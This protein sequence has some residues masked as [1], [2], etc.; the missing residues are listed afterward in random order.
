V[1]SSKLRTVATV[2]C[3]VLC[4]LAITSSLLLFYVSRVLFHP[5]AFADRV[6]ASLAEPGVSALVATRITDSLIQQRRN[7]VAFRPII[8]GTTESLISSAP[9]RAVVQRAAKAA[10]RTMISQ[11]GKDISLSVGDASVILQSALSSTPKL[12]EKIPARVTTLLGSSNEAPGGR[13][14]VKLVRFAHNMRIGAVALLVVG[15][16]LGGTAF[17]LVMDR[18][19]FLLRMGIALALIA[20]ILRLSVR[21]GGTTLA[22]FAKDEMVGGA[23]AGLWHA[24]LSGFMTWALILG[25]IGLVLAAGVTSL[26]SRVELLEIGKV[27]RNWFVETHKKASIRLLR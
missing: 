2:L 7:L 4:L 20:L 15:I 22:L 26:F 21:F 17:I 12:A 5:Q 8:L 3:S 11:R 9:F 19:R 24:F 14:I 6:S 1:G 16:L 18:R 13:I 25:A 27:I 10:H 23:I